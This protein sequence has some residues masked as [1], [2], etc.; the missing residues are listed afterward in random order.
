MLINADNAKKYIAPIK[1]AIYKPFGKIEVSDERSTFNNGVDII[2]YKGENNVVAIKDGKII[3]I[4]NKNALGYYVAI[5]HEDVRAVYGHLY[6]VYVKKGEE[7]KQGEKI[8]ILN[9]GKDGNR[10]LHFEVWENGKPINP[11]EVVNIN[12]KYN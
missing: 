2:P 8:G 5:E 10:Y 11:E 12:A 7:I 1:G 4:E 6:K 9:N 3:K